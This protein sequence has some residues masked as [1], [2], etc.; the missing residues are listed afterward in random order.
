M[1]QPMADPTLV[2]Q[3]MTPGM[4]IYTK[5]RVKGKELVAFLIRETS[6]AI[7]Q[8]GPSPV[9]EMRAGVM[10]EGRVVL[11]AVMVQVRSELYETW[12]NVYQRG[13]DGFSY[14]RTLAG[15]DQ[16]AFVFYGDKQRS[17]RKLVIRNRLNVFAQDALATLESATPWSMQEFDKAR[18]ALYKRYPTPETLWQALAQSQPAPVAAASR[19]SNVPRLDIVSLSD[20]PVSPLRINEDIH[21]GMSW[22]RWSAKYSPIFRSVPFSGSA[23]G[24]LGVGNRIAIR[25]LFDRHVD[26]IAALHDIEEQGNLSPIVAGAVVGA[27][28]GTG[29]GA[30]SAYLNMGADVLATVCNA[31]GDS[32]ELSRLHNREI[33]AIADQFIDAL[34]LGKQEVQLPAGVVDRARFWLTVGRLLWKPEVMRR[35]ADTGAHKAVVDSQLLLGAAIAWL[36][37]SE[38]RT[39]DVNG[40]NYSPGSPAVLGTLWKQVLE[41]TVKSVPGD[42]LQWLIQGHDAS[43]SVDLSGGEWPDGWK[44][45]N[46]D[47]AGAI[48]RTLVNEAEEHAVFVPLGAFRVTLPDGVPLRT[49]GTQTLRIWAMPDGLWVQALATGPGGPSFRWSPQEGVREF[50]VSK[51]AKPAV[52]ATLAALWRDLKIAGEKAMP[53][54]AGRQKRDRKR[55]K[56]KQRSRVTQ[57]TRILPARR[58]AF[59]LTGRHN[60]STKDEQERI[61]HRAHGVRGHLRQLHAGWQASA[62][63]QRIAHNFGVSVPQGYTFVRPHV[64]GGGEEQEAKRIEGETP[65]VARGLAT[66]ISLLG[67]NRR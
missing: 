1:T 7:A 54:Q 33:V 28:K 31:S 55:R 44:P 49:W 53:E 6:A 5:L 2:I 23:V 51:S 11:I 37:L 32:P 57:H 64:R 18:D 66:L 34:I 19:D 60:W 30:V 14:L 42:T 61:H 22:E 8:L 3:K 4:M 59:R 29:H 27:V 9:L 43:W 15:Q 48:A 52:D 50:L 38:R 45:E 46:N 67:G 63:A 16:V 20:V 36:A 25:F 40:A 12:L 47:L 21:D 39:L 35:L 13:A 41:W 17:E 58:S 10:V 62:E 56:G 24:V 65:I 26:P